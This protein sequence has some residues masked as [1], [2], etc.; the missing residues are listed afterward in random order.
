MKLTPNKSG[1]TLV[2]LMIAT[3]IFSVVMIISTY[4]FIQISRYYTKGLNMV[5]TQDLARNVVDE[6]AS[7]I[8]MSNTSVITTPDPG[9][10]PLAPD[11]SILCVGNK[12]YV[13]RL[14]VNEDGMTNHALISYNIRPGTCPFPADDST[15]K[16][17]L[18]TNYRLL[19][20]QAPAAIGSSSMLYNVS[21]KLLYSVGNDLINFHGSPPAPFDQW[22]CNTANKGSEYCTLSTISTVVYKRIK[23]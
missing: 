15:K 5:R 4:T 19:Q 12:S 16:V 23:G 14:G 3:S 8:K 6:I 21:V 11:Q 9:S 1:F 17:L 2:E 10:Q 18:R 20:F 13:Y 7:Q 22:T